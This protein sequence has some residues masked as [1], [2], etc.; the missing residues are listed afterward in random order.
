MTSTKENEN[1]RALQSRTPNAE[2][3]KFVIVTFRLLVALLV[4]KLSSLIQSTYIQQLSTK[5]I[6]FSCCKVKLW[7]GNELLIYIYMCISPT[8]G[9]DCCIDELS[10]FCKILLQYAIFKEGD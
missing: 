1:N 4:I 7:N 2:T 5:W 9:A 10:A 8:S 3:C 6:S